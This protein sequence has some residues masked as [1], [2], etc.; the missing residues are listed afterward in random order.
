MI[1]SPAAYVGQ[2]QGLWY[3]VIIAM[4]IKYV[5]YTLA[6]FSWMIIGRILLMLLVGSRH[7][8]MVDFFVRFTEPFYKITRTVFP[9]TRVSEER[10]HTAWGR[11]GGWTPFF[12][13]LLIQV[14]WIVIYSLAKLTGLI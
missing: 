8:V 3:E 7:N 6:F 10:E 14:L 2:A 9:F 11:I 5:K 4:V 1:R 13:L 12:A